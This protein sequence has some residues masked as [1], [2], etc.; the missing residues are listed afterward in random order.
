MTSMMVDT[1]PKADDSWLAEIGRIAITGRGRA[2][3]YLRFLTPKSVSLKGYLMKA[4]CCLIL[5][6]GALTAAECAGQGEPSRDDLDK[7]GGTWLTVSLVNDGKT[8]VDEK[9][10]SP[11]GPTTNLVYDGNT[12]MIK[13]GDKTVARG[14]FKIDPTK[15]P[16]EIDIMD[17]SG[18]KNDQ[19]KLGIYELE[20]DT[21]KYCLA[22][23]GKPRPTELKSIAGRGHILGVSNR[24]KP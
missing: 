5:T 22:P 1:E 10:L 24:A 18:V 13:V 16:K 11:K 17:E 3:V 19:T 6:T 4:V 7:L 20:V 9:A 15:M 23:A 14:V 21:Y 12:W 8:L 2:E